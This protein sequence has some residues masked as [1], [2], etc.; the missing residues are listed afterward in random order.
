[1]GQSLIDFYN[2]YASTPASQIKDDAA[3]LVGERLVGVGT[4]LE[5]MANEQGLSFDPAISTDERLKYRDGMQSDPDA[6]RFRTEVA[7]VFNNRPLVKSELT[8]EL[9]SLRQSIIDHYEKGFADKPVWWRKTR[10]QI[11][12]DKVL[13]YFQGEVNPESGDGKVVMR[14]AEAV[15]DE[16]RKRTP[17][18]GPNAESAI[19][20]VEYDDYQ[21]DERRDP[22][23]VAAR[24]RLNEA[25]QA[26]WQVQRDYDLLRTLTDGR[27]VPSYGEDTA[28]VYQML[29][30]GLGPIFGPVSATLQTGKQYFDAAAEALATGDTDPLRKVSYSRNMDKYAQGQTDHNYL[31]QQQLA[32]GLLGRMRQGLYYYDRSKDA[33]ATK[34]PNTGALF[35]DRSAA[36]SKGFGRMFGDYS[37]IYTQFAS[38]LSVAAYNPDKL[39]EEVM[40]QGT[41]LS[42]IRDL[43]MR[44]NRDTP[45]VPDASMKGL[46]VDAAKSSDSLER[47]NNAWS[48]IN[49]PRVGFALN[50]NLGTEFE[51]RFLSPAEEIG[52]DLFREVFSDPFSAVQLGFSA[53]RKPLSI[54]RH[55]KDEMFEEGPTEYAAALGEYSGQMPPEELQPNTFAWAVTSPESHPYLK[56][57]DGTPLKLPKGS[58]RYTDDSSYQKAL[59]QYEK[60][61]QTF[62]NEVTD[63][64]NRFRSATPALSGFGFSRQF[65]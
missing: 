28:A 58:G 60:Q 57:K 16:V 64:A 18:D 48:S 9:V 4:V 7:E 43:N 59:T 21:R 24:Y 56:N 20:D 47:Y 11:K 31:A 34:D 41:P 13:K 63:F 54:F 37:N 15:L 52:I 5:S 12:A 62:Q 23:A 51:P 61:R 42:D 49:Y 19:T 45:V 22:D 40:G 30:S 3:S 8:G 44:V 26:R 50:K 32:G 27:H 29:G 10:G 53:G 36:T 1:M 55:I 35:P 38:P 46:A 39:Y 14:A 25:G 6:E 65:K 2:Y 33:T 17:M